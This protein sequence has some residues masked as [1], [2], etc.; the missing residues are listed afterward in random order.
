MNGSGIDVGIIV[1]QMY[2]PNS[3]PLAA[4]VVVPKP[5]NPADGAD[6]VNPVNNEPP[7]FVNSAFG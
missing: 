1:R 3:P 2:L 4:L 7:G 6:D 5:P